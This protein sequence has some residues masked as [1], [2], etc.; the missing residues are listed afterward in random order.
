MNF[1]GQN[2]AV[3]VVVLVVVFAAFMVSLDFI[4]RNPDNGG[5]PGENGTGIN[6]FGTQETPKFSSCSAITASF[7]EYQEKSQRAYGGLDFFSLGMGLKSMTTQNAIA[8]M[9]SEGVA[10]S[11]SPRY[12]ETNIQVA[13]VDEADIVKT[14]GKYIYAISGSKLFIVEA[15]PAENAEIVSTISLST[16]SYAVNEMFIND[17]SLLVIGQGRGT[18]AMPMEKGIAVPGIIAQEY[19]PYPYSFDT[20]LVQ[21]YDISDRENPKL[22]REVEF[23]G[24]YVSSRKI[25]S[26]AYFVMS[27]YPQYRVLEENVSENE[28]IPKYRENADENFVPVGGCGDIGYLEPIAAESFV[29]VASISMSDYSKEITKETAVGSA[30]NVFA[31]SENLYLAQSSW[32]Y[33]EPIPLPLIGSIVPQSSGEST[34]VHK[35]SLENGNIKYLGSMDAPGHILNQFSMD[36]FEGYFRIA[37]TRGNVSRQGGGTSNNIYL[38]D[39]N[40]KRVGVLEDLA[41]GEK[42]YSARFMGNKAY[43]VTFKKVD[44]LFVIDL[45]EPSNPK[46]LGKLKI[47]GY[48]DYL[49]PI[50]ETHI[51]GLGKDTIEAEEGD[52]AWYQG[53]KLAVFDVSDVEHPKE[54]FK[55]VI[56][57]RGTDS[58]AL[59]DHKAFL[60]DKEKELLV[61]PILLAED[62]GSSESPRYS[63]MPS[64]GD[65]TFQGAYVYHLSLEDGFELQG[66]ISHID[67]EQVYK[68]SGYYFGGDEYSVKR[69]LFI[70]ETLYTFSDA[71]LKANDLSDLSEIKEVL[72]K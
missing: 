47:P 70:G 57:V 8:P 69:S 54:M 3:I 65:Y 29:T 21:L 55:E 60:F 63:G 17:N 67:D 41:P 19:Y 36:E 18:Y 10:G 26:D 16:N 2:S 38:F 25:G 50:D 32:N 42:I 72:L 45:S 56:G 53:I 15:Y 61:L 49:H 43:L 66:R 51:L 7:K 1:N 48:S 4:G 31:S 24:R 22:E 52:F 12:S 44:P 23:E 58:Y 33:E 20:T 59:R 68:K 34:K 62:T 13:G 40:L 27:S 6:L 46:V 39:K 14:D 5:T 64:Y 35:F 11:S 37:T 9:A 30:Q 71:M 28:I